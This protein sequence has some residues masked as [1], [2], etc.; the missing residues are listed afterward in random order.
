MTCLEWNAPR[1]KDKGLCSATQST[2]GRKILVHPQMLP[3]V[4]IVRRQTSSFCAIR[5]LQQGCVSCR[6]YRAEAGRQAGRRTGRPTS[7]APSI[8]MHTTSATAAAPAADAAAL[9]QLLLA[10]A[11]AV[12]AAAALPLL[13]LLPLCCCCCCPR[14]SPPT[15]RAAIRNS[16]PSSPGLPHPL[17]DG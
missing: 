4:P 17:A 7:R 15:R 14:L 16:T 8:K 1:N 9:L 3:R 12:A 6:S 11:A 13:L 10:A 5:C 2:Y